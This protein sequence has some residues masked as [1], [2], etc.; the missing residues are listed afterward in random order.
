MVD[1]RESLDG[2]I[3]NHSQQIQH[4]KSK[5]GWRWQKGTGIV[6]DG[7]TWGLMRVTQR[8]GGSR[9]FDGL[10]IICI[11]IFSSGSVC[12]LYVSRYMSICNVDQ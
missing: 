3:T 12:N 4:E 7:A 2:I 11:V 9:E 5:R 10:Y 6:N 1:Y 8:R